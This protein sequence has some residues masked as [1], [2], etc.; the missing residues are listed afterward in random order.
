MHP[1]NAVLSIVGDV[2]PDEIVAQVAELLA[3]WKGPGRVELPP[4]EMP[5]V[6]TEPRVASLE[7]D[8]S[9]VHVV[10]GFLGLTIADPDLHA[11]D[12]LTQ[13]LAGQGGRLFMELRDKRSLAYSVTAFSMEGV[14]PGSFG[15]Y[16]ASAPD[17]LEE[18]KEGLRSELARVLDEPI[19]ES[20]LDRARNYLIG[21]NDVGLQRYAS[22]ASLLS[23]DELYG[24]GA[25]HY[26]DYG[27]KIGAVT[28][29]DVKRVAKRIIK[30]DAPVLAVVE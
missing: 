17:K 11:L 16:I 13:I 30:L 25:A 1:S 24:L 7:K 8:K 29:D 28:L 10:M 6:P 27:D 20:E 26:L 19:E 14:D 18:A 4:R 2:T 22:Q 15:V 21:S 12:V 9:Q 5:K 23:L 3:D